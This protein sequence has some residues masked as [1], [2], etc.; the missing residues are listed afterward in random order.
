[1]SA[2]LREKYF[3]ADGDRS[4]L[5]ADIRSRVRFEWANLVSLSDF[6]P[7]GNIHVIFC[8]NVFIY[9]SPTSI[10]RVI[11]SFASRVPA[12]GHLFIGSSESLLKIT[13]DFE[14]QE[15]GDA[16]VYRRQAPIRP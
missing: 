12:D 3:K 15:L 14:L 9:F 7:A 6:P 11:G 8:R 16:F 4:L 10:K 13:S 5:H 1:L 2:K